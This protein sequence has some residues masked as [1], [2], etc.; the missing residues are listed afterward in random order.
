MLRGRREAGIDLVAPSDLRAIYLDAVNRGER[1]P[2]SFALG[3]HPID[4]VAASMRLPVDELAL[5]ARL[6]GAPLHVVRCVT[7]DI[8]VPAEAKA[9]KQQ[10]AAAAHESRKVDQELMLK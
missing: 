6:R 5:V 9:V 8:L 2:I 7:N 1:L 3:T 4:F 10:I